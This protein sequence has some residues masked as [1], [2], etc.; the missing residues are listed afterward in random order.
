MDKTEIKNNFSTD[1]SVAVLM[2]T[3]NHEKYIA[4]A[5]EGVL[6]Q[7]TD[8][9]VYLIISDDCSKDKTFVIASGFSNR[10]N[11]QIYATQ[12][13][14]NIGAVANGARQRQQGIDSSCKYI[15]IC[16]GDDYW[17]DDLKLQKQI[18]Y[19]E[20]NPDAI[21]CFTSIKVFDDDIQQ[22]V[23]YW[24]ANTPDIKFTMKEL[25]KGNIAPACSVVFRNR[26]TAI[27]QH[28]FESV[29]IVDWV[30]YLLLVGNGYAKYLNFESAVYRLSSGSFYSKNTLEQQ[31]E[32]KKAAYEYLLQCPELYLW[33]KNILMS[34]YLNLYSLAIRLP[35][36]DPTR[37]K[38]L[39][40]IIGRIVN[41]NLTLA[42]KALFKYFG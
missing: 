14:E 37:K 19:L 4:E 27:K 5:I 35:V 17:I 30:L 7:K 9:P 42:G 40:S 28:T 24:G 10:N 21:I 32:K 31:M 39:K 41:G 36:N 12:T 26:L 15:A 25:I 11:V 20:S 33:K 6:S 3:Y 34:Y 16:E 1:V 13:S 22:M 38:Y 8:F 29:S 23:P 2:Q 18:D